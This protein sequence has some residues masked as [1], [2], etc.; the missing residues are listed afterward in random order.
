MQEGWICDLLLALTADHRIADGLPRSS[1]PRC[2][3]MQHLSRAWDMGEKAER[4]AKSASGLLKSLAEAW[5]AET[6]FAA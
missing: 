1:L 2:S 3:L 5:E 4:V 6:S